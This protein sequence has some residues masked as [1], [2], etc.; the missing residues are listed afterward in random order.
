MRNDNNKIVF[1][2]FLYLRAIAELKADVRRSYIGAAWWVLDPLIYMGVFYVVF[3]LGLRAGGD[4]FLP[5]LLVG[6]VVWRWF[7]TSVKGASNVINSY[8]SLLLQVYIPKILLPFIPVISNTIKFLIVY[9][10]LLVYLTV[11]SNLNFSAVLWL[12]PVLVGQL[13]FLLGAGML[14]AALVPFLPDLKRIS[15]YGISLLFFMSGIF[16]SIQGMS[17]EVY[18]IFLYNPISYFIDAQRLILLAGKQPQLHLLLVH[19]AI[20]FA[21]LL[22]AVKLLVSQDK[23]Y[24][25]LS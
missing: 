7:D 14:L 11:S 20:S 12:L 18:N 17:P 22:L 19:M 10:I 25:I 4:N 6:L 24:P 21:L 1:L 13:F 8:K 2:R 15:D 16:Y 3:G 9:A 5:F 23:K